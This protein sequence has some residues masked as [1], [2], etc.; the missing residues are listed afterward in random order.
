MENINFIGLVLVILYLALSNPYIA[1]DTSQGLCIIL[2][3]FP[4]RWIDGEY[5]VDAETKI[6]H[7]IKKPK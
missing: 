5:I 4:G 1:I 2:T 3:R 6:Y 7:V